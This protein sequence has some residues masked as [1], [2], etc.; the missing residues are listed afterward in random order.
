M[1]IFE[2]TEVKDKV[3]VCEVAKERIEDLGEEERKS[4]Y[5]LGMLDALIDKYPNKE[6]QLQ[7]IYNYVLDLAENSW[8]D[9]ESLIV[10]KGMNKILFE[11]DKVLYNEQ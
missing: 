10:L 8:K 6:E 9:V 4:C 2:K 3:I 1:A 5:T 7:N 11:L